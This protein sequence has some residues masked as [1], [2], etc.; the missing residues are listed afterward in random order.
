MEHQVVYS[1]LSE[2]ARQAWETVSGLPM[3][4]PEQHRHAWAVL[5]SELTCLA[6]DP[7]P[8]LYV[9]T[10]EQEA[11][12]GT[13]YVSGPELAALRVMVAWLKANDRAGLMRDL[14]VYPDL[15]EEILC[16][17]GE[18]PWIGVWHP[19]YLNKLETGGTLLL[20]PRT[21]GV[22]LARLLE[23][24]LMRADK[25]CPGW[26]PSDRDRLLRL[27]CDVCCWLRAM[28]IAYDQEATA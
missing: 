21:E 24:V 10:N 17:L 18:A 7:Q 13:L 25:L 20:H 5:R 26:S 28:L 23:A 19:S 1:E 11:V 3:T 22:V 27:L 15:A 14:P 6:D 9:I 8:G 12:A 2:E 4:T 16:Q